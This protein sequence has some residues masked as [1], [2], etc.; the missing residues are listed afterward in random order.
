M[1]YEEFRSV[2]DPNLHLLTL[3]H[4]NDHC[5][6]EYYA[7][8]DCKCDNC[9]L[10]NENTFCELSSTSP[11]LKRLLIDLQKTHPEYLI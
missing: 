4:K 8:H 2:V 6:E 11:N 3:S 9:P 5:G 10:A 7:L 1:T